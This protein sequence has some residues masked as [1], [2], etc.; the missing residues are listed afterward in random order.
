M[1]VLGHFFGSFWRSWG[2]LGRLGTLFVVHFCAL[3]TSWGAFVAQVGPSWQKNSIFES[4]TSGWATK[5]DP[6]IEQNRGRKACCF[7]IRF[8]HRFLLIFGGI[9]HPKIDVFLFDF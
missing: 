3:G 5:L 4:L 1:V 8:L 6:K 7:Q 9:G 2:V